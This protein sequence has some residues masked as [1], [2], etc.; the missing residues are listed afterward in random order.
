MTAC[1]PIAAACF[2][3][4]DTLYPQR[5]WLHGAWDA[6]A[7]RAACEG[8]DERALRRAL[9]TIASEGS[10]RGRIIDRALVAV[11]AGDCPVAPLADAFRRYDPRVLEPFPGVVAGLERLATRVPLALVS[12]GDPRIQRAKLAALR[13]DTAFDVVVWSDE[14]GRKHR[15]PDP[16]PFRIAL[17]RLG[18][19]AAG[20]VFVGDRPDKDVAGATAVGLLPLRVRTGEWASQPDLPDTWGSTATV[21]EAIDLLVDVCDRGDGRPQA[22]RTPVSTRKSRSPGASR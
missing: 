13:L 16:L 8:V 3:L 7:A 15:K 22:S 11:G 18:V 14:H 6:V 4:D 1:Q 20:T 2:D 21:A 5:D 17:E 9:D 12:D 19:G 10:D